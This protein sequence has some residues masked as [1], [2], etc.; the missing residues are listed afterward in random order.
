MTA[1]QLDLTDRIEDAL[2][3][4]E[5]AATQA[6][7]IGRAWPI[8]HARHTRLWGPNRVL[9][10]IAAEKQDL[11]LAADWLTSA[12]HQTRWHGTVV[13]NRMAARWG[14]EP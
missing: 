6:Q 9:T 13:L 3:V 8:E 10:L 7:T 1:S 2:D 14:I 5:Q 4:A 12:D 11:E